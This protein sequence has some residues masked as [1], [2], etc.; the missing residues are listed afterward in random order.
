MQSKFS[1][2]SQIHQQMHPR[3]MP[4]HELRWGHR[5]QEFLMAMALLVPLGTVPGYYIPRF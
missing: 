1:V 2:L 5:G 4:Y 3:N